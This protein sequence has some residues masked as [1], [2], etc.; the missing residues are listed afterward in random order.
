MTSARPYPSP[1]APSPAHLRAPRPV[2]Y[3]H[4]AVKFR[5]SRASPAARRALYFSLRR[6]RARRPPLLAEA[7][8]LCSLRPAEVSPATASLGVPTAPR[9]THAPTLLFTGFA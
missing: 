1:A 5:A 8:S 7:P 4:A 6:T 3:A 2:L 9:L